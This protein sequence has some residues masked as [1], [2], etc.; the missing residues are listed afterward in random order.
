MILAT[1]A[2]TG[3]VIGKY[4]P[5][6]YAIVAISLAVH[7]FM[8]FIRHAE[9]F[10]D[11]VATIKDTWRKVA[12]D[13][14]FGLSTISLFLYSYNPN[15]EESKNIL[16]GA[17]FSML[18][19]LL[20]VIHWKYKKLPILPEIKKFHS[21]AHNYSKIPKYAPER[22]WNLRNAR[23]DIIISLLATAILFFI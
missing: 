14:I 9:Y 23:N 17:F 2:L 7:Y 11:R 16:L 15:F 19:D 12:L 22:Q 4:I 1:H 5:N 10:D 13:I 18:P 21:W 8:D 6:P 3:A 20:T